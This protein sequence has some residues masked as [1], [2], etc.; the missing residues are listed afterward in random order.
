MSTKM[1]DKKYS[2]L[3]STFNFCCNEISKKSRNHAMMLGYKCK[4]SDKKS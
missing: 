3:K 4:F 1:F 2:L